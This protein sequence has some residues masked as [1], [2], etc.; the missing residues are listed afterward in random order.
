MSIY[1]VIFVRVFAIEDEHHFDDETD[2]AMHYHGPEI[3]RATMTLCG[4][5]IISFSSEK[6]KTEIREKH[7]CVKRD[8]TAKI[9]Y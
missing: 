9:F 7:Q 8:S 2:Y 1:K 4:F 6:D 5:P 3:L